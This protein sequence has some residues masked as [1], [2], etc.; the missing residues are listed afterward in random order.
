MNVFNI[1]N[2][3]ARLSQRAYKISLLELDTKSANYD[4]PSVKRSR[5]AV[6]SD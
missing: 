2:N 4:K 5:P 6:R 1:A 3:V